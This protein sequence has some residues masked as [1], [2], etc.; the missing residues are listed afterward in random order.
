MEIESAE[1]VITEMLQ[2]IEQRSGCR[3]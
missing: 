3:L 1:Q 2:A